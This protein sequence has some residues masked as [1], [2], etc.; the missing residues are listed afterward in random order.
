MARRC[1]SPLAFCGTGSPVPLLPHCLR[2][3]PRKLHPAWLCTSRVLAA[4][5]ARPR[6]WR[7]F[8]PC[9]LPG[10][11]S[12]SRG[13]AVP[14]PASA[15]RRTVTPLCR[16]VRCEGALG[17]PSG[18]AAS[19]HLSIPSR[20]TG[21][22]RGESPPPWGVPGSVGER[23]PR[24][25]TPACNHRRTVAVPTGPV[26]NKGPWSL[27]SPPPL[28]AAS[29]PQGRR[30]WWGSVGG[31]ASMASSGPR[32]G[33]T[34]AAWAA[35][36]AA[37][38]GSRAAWTLAC[39]P[40]SWPVG[41][42]KGLCGPWSWGR[43]TRLT[44]RGLAPLRRRPSGTNCPRAAGGS[45]P[46]PSSPAVC[47]P[48]LSWVRRRIARRVVAVA[49]TRSVW[50]VLTCL[51][52]VGVAARASR[53]CR[54]RPCP[55]TARPVRSAHG[56]E[57]GAA[58]RSRHG[59]LVSPL[60]GCGHG[61]RVLP[62]GPHGSRRPVGL[63]R[64]TAAALSA[65][66]LGGVR[67]VRPRLPSVPSPCLAVGRPRTWGAEGFPRGRGSSVGSGPVGVCPPVGVREVAAPRTLQ[68]SCPR[69]IVVVACQPLGPLPV[70]A[71]F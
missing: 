7:N 59:F 47:G 5:H 50:R 33:R 32:P 64:A 1:W 41:M 28:R 49:R 22:H 27:G 51:P 16:P 10:V 53:S 17:R 9:G 39:L 29:S 42:P 71:V 45:Y 23:E 11:S 68:R 21:A 37:Q 66:F 12:S 31:R 60:P 40:R 18:Q 25:T 24:A 4:L 36:R 26:A 38:A 43:E 46:M 56:V 20:A 57:G 19:H 58:G 69:P 2:G 44:G 30:C 67:F 70:P 54:C 6:S 61:L 52:A 13:G 14:T 34:P 3:N 65:L 62:S 35:T 48:W 15:E 55:S 8:S 63:G